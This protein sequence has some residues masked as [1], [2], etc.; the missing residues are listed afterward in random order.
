M[1]VIRTSSKLVVCAG[2]AM[3]AGMLAGPAVGQRLDALYEGKRYFVLRDAIRQ[4]EQGASTSSWFF[5]GAVANKFNQP[6]ASSAWLHRYLD[7][8]N[9]DEFRADALEMLADNLFKTYE[10][11]LA[12]DVYRRLIEQY[13]D[14]VAPEDLADYRN[15]LNVS[16]VLAGV[17]AQEV[18]MRQDSRVA[19]VDGRPGFFPVLINGERAEM[20]FDTGANLSLMVAS[21]AEQ[22]GLEILEGTV[23]VGTMTGSKLEMRLAVADEIQL[24]Q[25]VLRHVVFLVVPN[26]MF[27]LQGIV[28]FPVIESLGTVTFVGSREVL[29][30]TTSSAEGEQNLALEGLTPL[31][32]G[33][34]AETRLVFRLDTGANASQLYPPFSRDFPNVVRGAAKATEKFGGVGSVAEVPSYRL[35]NLTLTV[36]NRRARFA[37]IPVLIDYTIEDSH[38]FHGNLGLDLVRQF[39]RMTIDFERMNIRF[40]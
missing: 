36:A 29:V 13:G 34:L 17:P 32:E 25:T 9:D 40:D 7:E 1:P 15:S 12:R 30:S 31:V 26:E 3:L 28:G 18:T 37:E 11:A 14:S 8:S 39:E 4:Q 10:Y 19:S 2:L 21:L 38:Y 27:H 33:A 22:A 24:G 23:D 20:I 35:K 5:K 16:T 6:E